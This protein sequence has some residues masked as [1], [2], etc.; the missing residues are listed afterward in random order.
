MPTNTAPA[1]S[2]S[3]TA[4]ALWS[5]IRPANTREPSVHRCPLTGMLP[6]TDSARPSTG[7]VR[8]LPLLRSSVAAAAVA[9]SIGTSD[10]NA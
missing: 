5:A 9:S 6:F 8:L 10:E 7:E 3:R 1:F 2:S 4:A